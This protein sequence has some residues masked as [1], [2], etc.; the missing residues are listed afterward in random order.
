[1]TGGTTVGEVPGV[2]GMTTGTAGVIAA[3]GTGVAGTLT[4]GQGGVAGKAVQRG[5]LAL[6]PGMRKEKLDLLEGV[7]PMGGCLAPQHLT[8]AGR[9]HRMVLLA[10]MVHPLGIDVAASFA[11]V[12]QSRWQGAWQVIA[13]GT[14]AT[15]LTHKQGQAQALQ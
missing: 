15:A 8:M 2:A 3:L 14:G 5:G 12:D 4:E 1:M 13:T 9:L 11:Q 6:L 10:N 7:P